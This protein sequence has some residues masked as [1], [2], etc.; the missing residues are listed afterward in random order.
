MQQDVSEWLVDE[1]MLNICN[2]YVNFRV[3]D[4]TNPGECCVVPNS[5]LL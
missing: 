3:S 1:F 2:V 5:C 4:V